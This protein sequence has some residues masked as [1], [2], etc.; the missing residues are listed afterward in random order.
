VAYSIQEF[1]TIHEDSKVELVQEAGGT[2]LVRISG[3]LDLKNST[4][5]SRLVQDIL[6]TIP[7]N[8]SL[9]LDLGRVDY[10]SSTGIGFL[11]TILGI[12]GKR[13]I[14]LSV[15]NI[16]PRVKNVMQLLGVLEYFQKE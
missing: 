12:A 6:E 10:V 8:G 13:S 2:T 3:E 11:T 15:A 14:H 4:D 9:K 7:S 1:N 5:L 16:Q